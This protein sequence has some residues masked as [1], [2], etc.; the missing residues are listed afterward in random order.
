MRYDEFLEQYKAAHYDWSF[1]RIDTATAAAAIAELRAVLPTV[2]PS[3]KRAD[4]EFL[5]TDFADEIS[6][7]SQGRMARAQEAI[8]VAADPSGTL[9]ERIA[10]LEQGMASVTRIADESDNRSEQHAILSMNETLATL[11]EVLRKKASDER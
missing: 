11:I 5:L 6:P 10:R 9:D 2:E 1:G 7:E 4:G 3:E 8:D